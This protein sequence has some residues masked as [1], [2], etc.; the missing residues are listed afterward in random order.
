MARRNRPLKPLP[1]N[2]SVTGAT[3][4]ADV[5]GVPS[6]APAPLFGDDQGLHQAGHIGNPGG[7]KPTAAM[8]GQM[9]SQGSM[10]QRPRGNT[11]S[12]TP[13]VGADV[14]QE[15]LRKNKG[16]MNMD[17]AAF[18]KLMAKFVGPGSA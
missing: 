1:G 3:P 2:S 14:M 13:T 4:V 15:M 8:G 17:S 10:M 9:A 11:A 16:I 6:G 5:P 7:V 12:P 18:E